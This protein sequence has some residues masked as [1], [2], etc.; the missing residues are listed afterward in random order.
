MSGLLQDL[1]YALRQLRKSTGFVAV[2]V[3]TLALGIGATAAMF[4]VID[5]VVLRPLPYNDVK[6]IVDVQT[7]P[8]GG[9]R[10]PISWPAYRDMRKLSTSLEALAGY[11]DYWGM[12][13]S[14]S[15]QSQYLNVTQGTDNFFDVFG[16]KPLLGRTFLPGEDQ[17]GKND[18]AVL[19]YEVWRKTFNADSDVVNKVVRLDGRPY[20]VIGVMPAG[21]RFPLGK[22]DLIYIPMHVRPHWDTDWGT[23]WVMSVGRLK[24]EATIQH[25]QA[26]IM[27]VM[28]EIGQEHPAT[29]KGWTA[30]LAPIE[31][32]LHATRSGGSELAEVGVMLGAVLAVLFIACANV[33]GLLLA[34]SVGREREMSLRVAVGAARSRLVRQLLVENAFLGLLGGG[35]GLLLASGLL[36]V[37][38]VFLAHAFMRGANIQLNVSVIS[39][40]LVAGV[41]SSI[42]A[43]LI[44]AWRTSGSSPSQLLTSG[45]KVGPSHRQRELR[46]GFVVAQISLSFILVVFSGLLLFTLRRMLQTNLGF[47]TKNLLTLGINIPSGDYE[48]RNFVT[49]LMDPLEQRVQST[50]GVTTAGFIDQMPVVGYGSSWIPHIVGQPP[51]PPDRQRLAETRTVSSGYFNAM[52]LRIVRGRNFSEQ[53]TPSSQPVAIVNEAFVK[54]FFP[55]G[56]DPLARAFQQRPGRPNTAIVGVVRDVRQDVFG[57]GRPEVDFPFSQLSEEIQRN[58]GSM[59]VALLIRTT[60]PS[61]SIVPQLRKALLEVAPTVAFQTPETMDEVLGDALVTNRMQSWLFGIFAGI[62]LLLAAIGL[63]GLLTQ[64]VMSRVRDI[65]V[66]MALGSTRIAIAQMMI[67]HTFQ[68]IAL[69]LG[70]GV[71]AT[72][73][74]RRVVSSV[75]LIQY[76]REGMLIAAL[77]VLTSLVGLLAALIPAHRA[78]KVDPMVALRYE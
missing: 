46:A 39:I 58:I 26:E 4:S 30:H 72:V 24:P 60:V 45:V 62:A 56:Q 6:R 76:D 37:M 61:N 68:L 33:A 13:L 67:K 70:F 78:A 42:G 11:E 22:P 40:T 47:S 8:W 36:S 12:T 9:S 20:V 51:D 3:I 50:P 7:S 49:S 44:P 32:T 10:Q 54:K 19:G 65:G 16:V 15:K 74:L 2:A 31:T 23:N 35:A 48:G 43:G 5:A 21:F 57:E 63:Y 69:G 66:R 71:L 17:P 28:Q 64:E 29:N 55:Q 18:V 25:A 14:T 38:R 1:R 53:D 34:R 41:L 27:H 77:I 52:G 75:L 59:S 73:V